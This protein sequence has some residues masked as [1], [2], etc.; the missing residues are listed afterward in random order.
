MSTPPRNGAGQAHEADEPEPRDDLAAT[1]VALAAELTDLLLLLDP[2]PAEAWTRPTRLAGWDVAILVAHLARGA[3]R[4]AE[5]ATQPASERPVVDRVS[6]WQFD[7]AA[8]AAGVDERARAAAAGQSPDSLRAAL[9]EAAQGV[10][11][12]VQRVAPQ[13]VAVLARGPMTL[14]EY[15]PTRV[16]EACV[17]G[18]D[19]RAAL[20]AAPIPTPD[21]LA[22]T[23]DILDQL[24][25]GPRPPEWADS[26]AF[27]EAA[28]GRRPSNDPCFPLIR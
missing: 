10:L 16:L 7:M 22:V 21:A 14:E 2:L 8:A 3:G 20:D 19:L 5:F 13:T 28:T 9:A 1:A 24:L 12:T 15:V 4:V 6:Y 27:I 26:V 23:L 18:L 11:Q 17:H 25:G